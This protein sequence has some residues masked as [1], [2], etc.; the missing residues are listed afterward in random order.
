MKKSN[1]ERVLEK[2]EKDGL[3]TNVWAIF[4]A[5]PSILRLSDIILHLRD[6]GYEI[7]TEFNTE[8]VGKNCHYY[9][10]PKGTLF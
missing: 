9:L 5:Y 7:E 2:L 8:K 10:K 1:K 6:E 3:V 4:E